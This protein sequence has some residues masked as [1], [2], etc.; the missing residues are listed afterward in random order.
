MMYGFTSAIEAGV[1]P[2]TIVLSSRRF[3][4]E[5]SHLMIR[6]CSL[7]VPLAREELSE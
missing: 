2:E 3:D 5:P 7:A 1:S 6:V 4:E